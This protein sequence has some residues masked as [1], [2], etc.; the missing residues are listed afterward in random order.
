[1][2]LLIIKKF[3]MY[4]T[5]AIGQYVIPSLSSIKLVSSFNESGKV[6]YSNS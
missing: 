2:S 1:M 6:Q 4:M 3:N 5:S